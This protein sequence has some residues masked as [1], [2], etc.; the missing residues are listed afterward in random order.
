[1]KNINITKSSK[2]GFFFEGLRITKVPFVD[3]LRYYNPP[4]EIDIEVRGYI[5]N[6]GNFEIVYNIPNTFSEYIQGKEKISKKHNETIV[7]TELTYRVIES[8]ES[9]MFSSFKN[10]AYNKLVE[11]IE[12]QFKAMYLSRRGYAFDNESDVIITDF[13]SLK[14]HI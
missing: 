2:E 10:I 7:K 6:L 9:G 12:P 8:E 5:D 14:M 11:S 3:K 1:M 4:S 13:N